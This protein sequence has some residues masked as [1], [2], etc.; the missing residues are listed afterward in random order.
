MTRPEDDSVADSAGYPTQ[1]L[2][3][4]AN[5]LTGSSAK[6]VDD[7]AVKH[8]IHF[9]MKKYEAPGARGGKSPKPQNPEHMND[10]YL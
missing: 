8:M 10:S 7:E 4:S 2:L 1:D 9:I 5:E 6:K 3:D